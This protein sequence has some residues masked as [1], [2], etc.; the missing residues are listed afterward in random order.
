MTQPDALVTMP[1]PLVQYIETKG[2][3]YEVPYL[4]HTCPS[5]AARSSKASEFSQN[6][7]KTSS[8][9]ACMIQMRLSHSEGRLMVADRH[10][11]VPTLALLFGVNPILVG[12]PLIKSTDGE[13][14]IR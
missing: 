8:R 9:H 2:L 1:Q 14:G 11:S 6:F 4:P 5:S 10:L 3:K 12:T 7:F 13:P